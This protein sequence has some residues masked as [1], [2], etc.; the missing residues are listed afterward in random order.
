MLNAKEVTYEFSVGDQ[1]ETVILVNPENKEIG[2]YGKIEAHQN[3]KLHRAFSIFITNINGELLLQKRAAIKYH[4]SG[5]WSNTC[6]GHPR[7]GEST[8]AAAGR[9]LREEFGFAVPLK[10]IKE[11]Q[12]QALDQTSG[13]IE[14]EYLH[15]FQGYYDGQPDPNPD[16]IS[17]YRWMLPSTVH[18]SLRRYPDTFTP[19]FRILAV[20]LIQNNSI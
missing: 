8:T 13:L 3:G 15:V 14:N 2:S 19:W 6:C 11:C 1:L 17:G 16:E 10:E 4:F 20:S 9:R 12:Y 7:P 18:R 5:L